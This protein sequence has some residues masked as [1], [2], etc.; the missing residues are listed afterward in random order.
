LRLL[1]RRPLRSIGLGLA[2]LVA[3]GGVALVLLLVRLRLPQTGAGAVL[4]AFF[5]AQLAAASVGWHRT[6]RIVGFAELARADAADRE[7]RSAF[8]MLPPEPLSPA[9]VPALGTRSAVLDALAPPVSLPTPAEGNPT[10]RLPLSS[11]PAPGEDRA[12]SGPRHSGT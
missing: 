6:A 7:R 12:L 10:E 2:T 1:V 4:L 5:L 9:P 11:E 3:G 8:A